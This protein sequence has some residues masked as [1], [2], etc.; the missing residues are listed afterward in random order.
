MARGIE[1]RAIFSDPPDNREIV[2]R[3][4]YSLKKSA[5]R[6]SAR[7]RNFEGRSSSDNLDLQKLIN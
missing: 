1:R 6:C 3:M 7:W 4:E 5:C 2:E